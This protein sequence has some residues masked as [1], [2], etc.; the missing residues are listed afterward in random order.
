[1]IAATE[2]PRTYRASKRKRIDSKFSNQFAEDFQYHRQGIQSFVQKKR[3]V[4][5]GTNTRHESH[6]IHLDI[7]EEDS[8]RGRQRFYAEDL[9]LLT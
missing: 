7:E 9:I 3:V 6:S 1:M 8:R 2:V 5:H 4:L